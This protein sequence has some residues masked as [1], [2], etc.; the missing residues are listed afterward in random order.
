MMQTTNPKPQSPK[1]RATAAEWNAFEREYAEW[2]LRENGRLLRYVEG[3]MLAVEYTD[4]DEYMAGTTPA[5]PT[6][7]RKVTIS[8][9]QNTPTPRP[10]EAEAIDFIRNYTGTF[11]LIL[12]LRADRRFGSKWFRLS[13]R[14][15]EVVLA[16][17]AREAKWAAERQP[18]ERKVEAEPLTH[19]MYR[20]DGVIYKVQ[21]AVHGSGHLYAKVL[22]VDGPGEG[23]FEYA[24][25]AVRTLTAADRMTAEEAAEFG[26]LYGM[27]IV[28]G[29]TLTDEESIE[30]GIGPICRGKV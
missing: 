24:Q 28:C 17:K 1:G 4:V 7:D 2:L 16:S 27:C 14:Q 10:G 23:H 3:S 5:D 15:I 19:G 12:D 29:A 9:G 6:D 8:T 26:R 20:K 25:G 11:G 30:R 21:K 18:V 22:I 13:D